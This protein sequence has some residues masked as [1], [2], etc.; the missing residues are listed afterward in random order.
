MVEPAAFRKPDRYKASSYRA[1]NGKMP[2]CYDTAIWS[3]GAASIDR[4]IVEKLGPS[5]RSLRTLDIGCATGRR[6]D[7]LAEAGATQ[8]AGTDLAPN[9][10]KV[11]EKKL[12]QRG[13][14]VD[15]RIADAEDR[16][17][18]DD[19]SFDAVTLT[20]VLHHFF[21]PKDAIAEIRRVLCP[22]GRLLVLDACFFPL[23]RQVVNMALRVWPHDGDYDFYGADQAA[24]LLN[25]RRRGQI[26]NV[27][28]KDEQRHR[29]S[30]HP[31]DKRVLAHRLQRRHDVRRRARLEAEVW[32]LGKEGIS[33]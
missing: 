32:P 2:S 25:G 22:G 19:E 1:Y 13:A 15:L 20:G 16:L 4:A 24:G 10:L 33:Q 11:A 7:H 14:P 31:V 8:L 5:I 17:P 28:V 21:R 26:G 6:L 12:A 18:W 23:V 9:I 3:R 29:N 30:Y 27:D